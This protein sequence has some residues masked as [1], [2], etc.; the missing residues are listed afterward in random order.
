MMP[1]T[2]FVLLCTQYPWQLD[3]SSIGCTELVGPGTAIVAKA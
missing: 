3:V 1:S 2:F